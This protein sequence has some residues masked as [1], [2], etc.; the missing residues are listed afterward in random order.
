SNEF[1]LEQ[2]GNEKPRADRTETG[3]TIGGPVIKEKFFFF[4]GYQFTDANTGLVPTART[5]T[6]L[7]LALSVLG[8]DR[9]KAAIAAA[10]NQFN[11]CS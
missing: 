4:G 7:P 10:F 8:Q 5:R 9:S 11:G 1:L 6:I 2:S 3:F